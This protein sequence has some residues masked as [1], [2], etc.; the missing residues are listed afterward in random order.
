LILKLHITDVS[1]TN[2]LV[3]ETAAWKIYTGCDV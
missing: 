1:Q 2:T 3:C